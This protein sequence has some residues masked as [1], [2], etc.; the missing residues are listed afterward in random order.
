MIKI[1]NNLLAP[2]IKEGIA[3]SRK[4]KNYNFH[5]TANDLMHRMV[6]A[7]NRETYV[8]PH[9]H[10]N[11]DKTEAFIILKGRILLVEFNDKGN[12]TDH[13]IMDANQ[14]NYGVEIPPRTWH[15]LITLED[16]SVFYEVKNG[17]WD[18]TDDKFFA[19]WSPSEGD[20]DADDYLNKILLK[21]GLS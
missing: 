20:K 13:F 11:P 10:E 21:L 3:S 6:H 19:P 2:I 15:M 16:N 12:I 9:K 4:R 8:Q 17:P 5:A 18:I 7:S 1:N 14:G